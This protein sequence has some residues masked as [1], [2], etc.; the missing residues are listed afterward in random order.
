MYSNPIV[1]LPSQI[2]N[3]NSL[4]ILVVSGCK[5]NYLPVSLG[6]LILTYSN[7]DDNLTGWPPRDITNQEIEVTK[8]HLNDE[9]NKLSEVWIPYTY[10]TEKEE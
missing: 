9:W 5:L 3:C 7:F 8:E 6:N 10:L 2:G 1:F 4:E